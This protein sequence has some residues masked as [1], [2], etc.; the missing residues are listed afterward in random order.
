MILCLSPECCRCDK[1]VSEYLSRGWDGRVE[2]AEEPDNEA[3][4]GLSGEVGVGLAICA[5]G[6]GCGGD[7]WRHCCVWAEEGKLN[8]GSLSVKMIPS[9]YKKFT[10]EGIQQAC[11]H[12]GASWRRRTR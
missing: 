11:T 10:L 3:D 4:Q 9:I 12:P 8:S 1:D 2:H 7:A 6:S 5:R